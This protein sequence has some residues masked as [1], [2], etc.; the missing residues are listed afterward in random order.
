MDGSNDAITILALV[1]L[2]FRY[3]KFN[4]GFSPKSYKDE[5]VSIYYDGS[6]RK[7]DTTEITLCDDENTVVFSH[8]DGIPG[9]TSIFR[10]GDWEDYLESLPS[11]LKKA[12]YERP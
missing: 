12:K 7:G 3:E 9:H 4:P 11:K 2:I 6:F 5:K 8:K 10:H 1:N